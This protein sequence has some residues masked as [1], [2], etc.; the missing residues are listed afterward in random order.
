MADLSNLSQALG[1]ASLT[2]GASGQTFSQFASGVIGLAGALRV[3]S[4]VNAVT[5]FQVNG[6]SLASTHLSDSSSLARLASPTFSGNPNAPTPSQDDNDTSIATTQFVISQL[7]NGSMAMDGTAAAGTSLRMARGDHVHPTDTSRAP[8][9]SPALTG[10]PTAPTPSAGDV[11]TKIA[12]TAFVA[13]GGSL[14]GEM[15]IWPG[16]VIPSGYLACDGSAQSRTTFANLFAALTANKGAA[17]VTIASPG[18][19]SLNSHGLG[20]GDVIFVETTGALPT[21]LSADVPYFVVAAATNTFQ[22]SATKGGAAI[23]TSGSQ[24]GTH[25]IF[26]SPHALGTMSSTTFNVPD[27]RGKVLVSKNTGTF[28]NI[29][30]SGGEE[31]HVITQAE[32][33]SHNHGGTSGATSAGTPAG[34][35]TIAGSG[36]LTT[37]TDSVDHTHSGTTLSA[38]SAGAHSHGIHT[39]DS[40]GAIADL[41]WTNRTGQSVVEINTDSAGAHTHTISGSTGGRSVTHTHTVASHGHTGSTFTGDPLST[42]THSISSVGSDAAHNNLQPYYVIQHIIKT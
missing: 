41:G 8:L 28:I 15:K 33:A 22:V 39:I 5:G 11:S 2:I 6:T 19:W 23:N 13:S 16:P 21:G 26:Q 3:S 14:A 25:T 27:T 10:T 37:G 1:A 9:N 7:F 29:G 20:N 4:L 38:V 24:S 34:T 32:M 12:T 31:T 30:A 42:H 17:T 35:V 36:T 40:P 18:V